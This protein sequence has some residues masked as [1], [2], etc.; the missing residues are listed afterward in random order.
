MAVVIVIGNS[1]LY[2]TIPQHIMYYIAAKQ[3]PPRSPYLR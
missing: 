1:M 2:H 3:P